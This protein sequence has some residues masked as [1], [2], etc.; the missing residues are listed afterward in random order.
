ALMA[1]SVQGFLTYRIWMFVGKKS[2]I[3]IIFLFQP[4]IMD[5]IQVANIIYVARIY[6][7]NEEKL[8]LAYYSISPV[9]DMAIAGF[10]GYYLSR[11]SHETRFIGTATALQRL[12]ILSINT[13]LW[14][15]V[16]AFLTLILAL[17]LPGTNYYAK[18]GPISHQED[19]E[20]VMVHR[21]Q[22]KQ[23][24]RFTDV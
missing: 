17:R 15:T 13:G 11:K 16:F 9:V 12:A 2:I 4:V 14:T 18:L 3:P 8:M 24:D 21:E 20:V 19:L 5:M 23:V 6:G 10:M 22:S 7:V 1:V